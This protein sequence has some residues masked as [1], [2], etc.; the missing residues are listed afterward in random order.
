[1]KLT[2]E[3]STS[4]LPFFISI[5]FIKSHVIKSH[6]LFP[7][8]SRIP[9]QLPFSTSSNSF[10]HLI[11]SS[12]FI[13][14]FHHLI[15]NQ[16]HCTTNLAHLACPPCM[17]THVKLSPSCLP[18]LALAMPPTIH[19]SSSPFGVFSPEFGIRDGALLVFWSG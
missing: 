15:A 4:F 18:T 5:Q 9:F 1:M 17:P 11:S 6:S 8:T 7:S 19:P 13:I 10:H 14:S 12:H 3:Y 2:V 16:C